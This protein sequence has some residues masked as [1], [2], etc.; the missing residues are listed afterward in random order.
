MDIIL[1]GH[2]FPISLLPAQEEGA[3]RPSTDTNG[4]DQPASPEPIEPAQEERTGEASAMPYPANVVTG[5]GSPVNYQV[6]HPEQSGPHSQDRLNDLT[7][8]S[9]QHSNY[10]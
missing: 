7:F 9:T 3:R 2:S 1:T 5:V 6:I 4:V 10:N 8:K